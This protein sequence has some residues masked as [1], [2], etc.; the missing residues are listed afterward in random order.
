MSKFT[1][2]EYTILS[3]A[4]LQINNLKADVQYFD[5]EPDILLDDVG[6][7][8]LLD[9]DQDGIDDFE[10][11]RT[12]GV[13]LTYWAYEP[14]YF[15]AVIAGALDEGNWLAGSYFTVGSA[16]YSSFLTYRPY[17]IPIGYPIGV[18]LSFQEDNFQ[19]L[20]AAIH[21]SSGELI[22]KDG[23]WS[24]GAEGFIGTRIERDDNYYYGW[25]R[26][27]VADS[28][29]SLTIHNYALETI[30]GKSLIT[31]D[32]IGNVSI[33]TATLQGPD[34]TCDGTT[35]FIHFGSNANFEQGILNIYDLSGKLVFNK[36]LFGGDEAIQLPIQTG[37][38]IATYSTVNKLVSGK[39]TII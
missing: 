1:L 13:Y 31:G 20:A 39:I 36:Q 16:A 5:I 15:D 11:T 6:E 23:N 9:I 19:L 28:A 18:M 22:D 37:S 2:A 17:L 35:L 30:A 26:V 7:L 3:A 34:I 8:F 4:F 32:S 12:A 25:V 29:K 14:R 38:Y 27:T 33:A 10:F 24:E 21:T